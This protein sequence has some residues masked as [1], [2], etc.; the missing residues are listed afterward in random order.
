VLYALCGVVVF[1]GCAPAYSTVYADLPGVARITTPFAFGVVAWAM[2]IPLARRREGW[3]SEVA[4][5]IGYVAISVALALT[6]RRPRLGWIGVPAAA[7]FGITCLAYLLGVPASGLSRVVLAEAAVAARV[8]GWCRERHLQGMVPEAMW[9]LIYVYA[10]VLI[11]LTHSCPTH[12]SIWHVVLGGS[13]AV[14]VVVARADEITALMWLAV[15]GGAWWTSMIAVAVGSATEA[16]LT[17]V[18]AGLALA[19]LGYLVAPMRGPWRRAPAP[20]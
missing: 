6:V 5:I 19:G 2:S 16:A 9:S 17:V 13:V 15:A 1:A 10:T 7:G 11:G 14:A 12:L 4:G 8:A 20:Q 3:Q 18:V